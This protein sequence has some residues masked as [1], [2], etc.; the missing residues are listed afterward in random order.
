MLHPTLICLI[1]TLSS[2]NQLSAFPQLT[3]VII[4]TV[5]RMRAADLDQYSIIRRSTVR[6]KEARALTFGVVK[7]PEK[8]ESAVGREA[9]PI[10]FGPLGHLPTHLI[11]LYDRCPSP[12]R[13]E[14]RYTGY[15]S[16]NPNQQQQLRPG[17]NGL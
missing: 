17:L 5:T 4:L 10:L 1:M 6:V 7:F 12:P 9:G 3:D 8:R 13:Y 15:V 16:P 2:Y 11:D 14:P